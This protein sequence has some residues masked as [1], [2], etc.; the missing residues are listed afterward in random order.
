MSEFFLYMGL[1][2]LLLGAAIVAAAILRRRARRANV[3]RSRN[4]RLKVSRHLPSKFRLQAR[5]PACLGPFA[6]GETFIYSLV[7]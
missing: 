3:E 1:A 4:R 7:N 2:F 6:M 5:K